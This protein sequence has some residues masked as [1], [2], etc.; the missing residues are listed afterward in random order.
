MIEFSIPLT[1]KLYGATYKVI[2][3]TIGKYQD[4]TPAVQAVTLNGEP[5][6]RLTVCVPG[7]KLKEDEILVKTW[8]ENEPL[9]QAAL[10][11]K[12]FEN[13]GRCVPTGHCHAEVWRVK[14]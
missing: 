1:V 11:S 2:L 8:S 6:G 10:E 3:S 5:F 13:T 7:T 12:Y 9:A 14:R 4:G